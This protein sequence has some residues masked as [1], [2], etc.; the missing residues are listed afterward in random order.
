[1][2]HFF[3]QCTCCEQPIESHTQSICKACEGTLLSSPPLC[4][5]CGS[6]VCPMTHSDLSCTRPWV[7]RINQERGGIHSYSARYLM[8]G[9]GYQVLKKWKLHRGPIFDRQVLI[10]NN[11]LLTLWNDFQAEAVIPVP[12]NFF[13][14]WQ[15]RGSPAEVIAQWVSSET[16]VP[17]QKALDIGSLHGSSTKR[18]A[19]KTLGERL[20]SGRSRFT[21]NPSYNTLPKNVLLVDDFMT[22]GRTLNEAAQTLKNAGVQKIHAFC[23]GIRTFHSIN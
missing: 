5:E 18:Q 2:L 1:M 6:P 9:Q 21:L 17:L 7:A 11:P 4:P 3:V 8:I 20:A 10:S 22:T 23:L 14:S 15:M 16:Q 13:R 19:Q 12:Q